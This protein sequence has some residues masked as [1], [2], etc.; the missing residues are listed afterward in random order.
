MTNKFQKV[1]GNEVMI[2]GDLH[3]SDVFTGK[4]KDYLENCCWVM[5][6]ITKKLEDEK[7]SALVLAGDL[8]G[9]SETNI[10]SREVLS[11]FIKVL[12]EWN[13]VCPVYAVRGNHDM[14]GYPDFNFLE[15]LGMII[16]SAECEGY[17]DYYATDDASKPEV[18]FH[19]VDYK[20]ESR[21]L[22]IHEDCSNIVIGHNNYTIDGVT[23]WYRDHDGIELGMLSNFTGVDM[24]ISGHIHNPSPEIYS[25][26]MIDGKS[27]MLFYVGCP[28]RPIREGSGYSYDSC[29]YVFLRYNAEE[30]MTDIVTD[31]FKLKPAEE[32]FYQDDTFIEEATQEQIEESVR[33]EALK[34]VLGDLLVY[35]MNQTDPISQVENIPNASE[36]AK[37]VAINYLNLAFNRG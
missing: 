30:Q 2:V 17:F 7:P 20:Q 37:K 4:H 25:V 24:V 18:R 12:K 15:E 6:Q 22:D 33:Q 14:K 36:E 32:V 1:V 34:N 35:R 31:E 23:T 5:G 10:K 21:P 9:W 13:S 8:I 19:L 26:Q 27:C 29:W 16:T 11:M 3:F 28:S